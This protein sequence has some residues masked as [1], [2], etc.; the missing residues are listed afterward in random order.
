MFLIIGMNSAR[1]ALKSIQ[2]QTDMKRKTI[3]L[4]GR[5]S[6]IALIGM[7]AHGPA[8]AGWFTTTK[9]SGS[10]TKTS[11]ISYLINKINPKPTQPSKPESGPTPTPP[12]APTPTPP[13]SSTGGHVDVP[14]PGM[15]GLFGLGVAGLA[16]SRRRR[17]KKSART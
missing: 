9:N 8:Q 17:A 14:E 5:V 3:L 12:P 13:P 1:F 7:A 11:T 2:G 6:A 16:V 10:S 15:V 4:L